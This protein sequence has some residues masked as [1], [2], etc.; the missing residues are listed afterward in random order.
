MT[1][2]EDP[3]TRV[4][5]ASDSKRED[6][7]RLPEPLTE[8]YHHAR[9]NL[10]LASGVLLA[11]SVVGLDLVGAPKIEDAV[12]KV[13]KPE[14][15]P[16][17]LAALVAFYL[18]RMVL[19]FLEC[20]PERTR[21]TAPR[22]DAW[23]SGILA[24]VALASTQYGTVAQG[25][26]RSWER[27]G[28]RALSISAILVTTFGVLAGLTV[29]VT[30]FRRAGQP[31]AVFVRAKALL[32]SLPASKL[33]AVVAL[34]AAVLEF[35][36]LLPLPLLSSV[37]LIGPLLGL[38]SKIQSERREE[39]KLRQKA[40]GVRGPRS[41]TEIAAH[42]LAGSPPVASA[43]MVI[44]ISDDGAGVGIATDRPLPFGSPIVLQIG[45]MNIPAEV[46]W[47]Q[48]KSAGL[49]ISPHAGKR[50]LSMIED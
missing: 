17:V 36:G 21:R 33:T 8:S 50:V 43:A 45:Q 1:E 25:V 12:I 34:V 19:E 20:D 35:L 9:R 40:S 3:A 24:A 14:L 47:S 13:R 11:W 41:E 48:A 31:P 39:A 49:K 22:V 44:N 32:D 7:A 38:F 29:L 18:C 27:L 15:L 46:V 2:T 5:T 16:W 4:T 28:P 37:L 10:N 23:G 42:I 26:I 6:R 30:R